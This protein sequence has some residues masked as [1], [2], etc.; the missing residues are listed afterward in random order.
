MSGNVTIDV[1]CKIIV[2]HLTDNNEGFML[3]PA[4]ERVRP[5]L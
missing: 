5:W 3:S 4:G 1:T 2:G